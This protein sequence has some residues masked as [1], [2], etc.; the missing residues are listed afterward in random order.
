MS[1]LGQ[2]QKM[3]ILVQPQKHVYIGTGTKT[4]VYWDSHKNM[5]ILGQAQKHV[6]I[7]TATKRC[8][9]GDS[10]KNRYF[11]VPVPI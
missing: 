9:Y 6:Y 5:S 7:G 8:L 2:A 11:F 1:I 10:H 3:F 4:C